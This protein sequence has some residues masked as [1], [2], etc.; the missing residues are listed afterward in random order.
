MHLK[1]MMMLR[2]SSAQ[3][4]SY[5]LF[6]LIIYFIKYVLYLIITKFQQ[7]TTPLENYLRK[8]WQWVTVDRGL[9]GWVFIFESKDFERF[10]LSKLDT[11]TDTPKS[12]ENLGLLLSY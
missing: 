1:T 6:N 9:W 3:T 7:Q 8:W 12:G 11:I 2:I 5:E 10:F 4:K